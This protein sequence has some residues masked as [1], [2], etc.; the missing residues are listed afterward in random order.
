M[1]AAGADCFGG[2]AI[3]RDDALAGYVTSGSFGHHLGQSLALGYV[4]SRHFAEVDGFEVEVLGE[5]RPARLSKRPLYD[6]E[7][8]RMRQ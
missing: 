2:E 4:K 6:P 5:R 7:A 1:G 3:Y 8:S